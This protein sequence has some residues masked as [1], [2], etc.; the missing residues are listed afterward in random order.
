MDTFQEFLRDERGWPE[1]EVEQYDTLNELIDGLPQSGDLITNLLAE[2]DDFYV[3]DPGMGSGHFLTS[4]IEEIVNVRHELYVQMGGDSTPSRHR[5]KKT[6]VLNNIYGVDIVGPAVEIGKLRLW[7]SII[8]EL[9]EDDVDNLS[10]NELALPNIAFNLREGNSLIGFTGF[11]EE[12]AEG[13]STFERY[14]DDSVR[15]RYEDIIEE[16]HAYQNAVTNE[17]A[18]QHRRNAHELLAEAREELVD[19][20]K[21]EFIAAGISDIT[22]EDIEDYNPFH[23][24][25]E[26]AEV[27]NEGGFD[28]IVGNPPWDVLTP[29]R[30]EFFSR[31]DPRFRTRPRSEKDRIQ[32][33]LLEESGT[34]LEWEKYQENMQRRADYFND[35]ASY[36]L[37]APTINGKTVPNNQNELSALFLERVYTLA[38]S[39]GYVAQVLPST[40]FTGSNTKDVRLHLLNNTS[41]KALIGFENHGIFKSI[42]SRYRFSV[43]VFK[44]SGHSEALWGTFLQRD[45]G[46]LDQ[47]REYAIEIPRR[48]LA[49]YSPEAR[50]FP[51][52]TTQ[53]EVDTLD[54]ILKH[55]AAGESA[56]GTWK[57]EPY[58]ELD[59]TKDADR[60]VES[61]EQG[62]YPVYGGRNMYQFTY[63]N[64]F[65]PSIEE[66]KLWSVH[67]KTDPDKS[68]KQRMRERGL[69]D[70]K[71]ALYYAFNGEKTNQSQISFVNELLR[72]HRGTELSEQDVLLD[73]TD[74]RIVYREIANSTNERTMIA[75]VIPP[76]IVCHHKLHTV[77]AHE[78]QPDEADLKMKNLHSV[79]K[80]V[81]SDKELFVV[82]GLL[83]SI[84]FDFLMRT[85]IDTSIV[86][87]KMRESQIPHLIQGDE[88]FEYIWTRAARL[89]CYGDEFGEMRDRL[90]G[91]E[92]AVEPKERKR[93]QAELDAA[94]FHAYGLD[95]ELTEFV[96]DDFHRVREPRMM[97]D[98]YFELVLE[99]YDQL[100]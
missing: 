37:Q 66:P 14:Q 98:D 18:D 39:D 51:Y 100:T 4:V 36:S 91:I 22:I 32:S 43:T 97:T 46:V 52:V 54:Q 33:E 29:N 47:Y 58:R 9:A 41:V 5:L 72:R 2:M 80:R 77:V 94:A 48:V 12:T 81:F 60:I 27:F 21:D 42:D 59:R 24:V 78:I 26:F 25:L 16:I 1:V 35:S 76:G 82:T 56:G 13:V 61:K 92:P 28:A 63:D 69:S 3:L 11:A 74:Y 71:R 7:L 57:I 10:E 99:K 88:W 15:S 34:A 19:E 90:G 23:W 44:N 89:N 83:N 62:D 45:L 68:A 64:T 87:Y 85:K 49:E 95:R 20:I 65:Y 79:Y 73:C 96:L 50:T 75:S 93:V 70:L 17:Q 40:I 55:P 8:A 53:E 30:E 6:T 31:Y 86:M 67:S 38:G 84:P